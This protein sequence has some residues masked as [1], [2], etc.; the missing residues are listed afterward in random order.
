MVAASQSAFAIEEVE[1][2][3]EVEEHIPSKVQKS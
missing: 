2:V 3:E 1:E